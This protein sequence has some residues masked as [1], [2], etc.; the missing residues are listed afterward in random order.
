[1]LMLMFCISCF[2][3]LLPVLFI[4]IPDWQVASDISEYELERAD[5]GSTEF[6]VEVKFEFEFESELEVLVLVLV[7]ILVLATVDGN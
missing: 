3:I 2:V 7:L 6:D 1:M 5:S 4:E